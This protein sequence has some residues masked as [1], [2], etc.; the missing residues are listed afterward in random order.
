MK[1]HSLLAVAILG[2][3]IVTK[4]QNV[5]TNTSSPVR[6]SFTT[7]YD[8]IPSGVK[9][10]TSEGIE[11]N[12][13]TKKWVYINNPSYV[14]F[15]STFIG[16]SEMHFLAAGHGDGTIN[17]GPE[18]KN[19]INNG[20]NSDLI[21]K[22]TRFNI[23]YNGNG[24]FGGDVIRIGCNTN[25]PWTVPNSNFT[26]DGKIALQLYYNKLVINPSGNFDGTIFNKK[27]T[28]SNGLNLWD[29]KFATNAALS[30]QG[31]IY[32]E[33]VKVQLSTIWGDYVFDKDYKL[34]SLKTIEDYIAE[35]HHLPN[36]P[37]AAE[38]KE[39]GL[40]MEEMQRL[41]MVKIE[42]LTLYLI[43]QNKRIETLE[44][45]IQQLTK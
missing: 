18:A 23:D 43:E 8:G 16:G 39:N 30:V 34:N 33:G 35:N 22:F 6:L 7:W 29:A 24:N 37:S 19:I 12:T 4:S 17:G 3:A 21:N 45:Q 9:V 13:T 36:V 40:E 20:T 42:E 25:K 32:C 28:I 41:H 11:Y 38:I 5:V 31:K 44:Q 2:L 14:G 15:S 1:K 10:A 27:V 26:K